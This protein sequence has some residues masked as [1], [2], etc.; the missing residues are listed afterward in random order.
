MKIVL[1]SIFSSVLI[2]AG[3]FYFLGDQPSSELLHNVTEADGKQKI[4]IFAKGGYS[5]KKTVAKANT[6]TTLS[7]NTNGTFDCSSALSIPSLD[8]RKHLPSSGETQI[9]LPPQKPG[10]SLEGLCA[11]GMYHFL[12]QFE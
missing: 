5:P 12:V 7:I 9:E 1:I 8:F 2:V 11:M 3:M 6:P 4:E 10:S